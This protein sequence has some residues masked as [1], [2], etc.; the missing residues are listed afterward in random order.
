MRI[1][2][3]RED[4]VR[5][6][7]LRRTKSTPSPPPP[8]PEGSE[9]DNVAA[10]EK[11]LE[12]CKNPTS[13]PPSPLDAG[14]RA[15][16][17]PSHDAP[18]FEQQSQKVY[19][20]PS[21]SVPSPSS[22][23]SL[24]SI[25]PQ[26][27]LKSENWN[28]PKSTAGPNGPLRSYISAATP[29]SNHHAPYTPCSSTSSASVS[30][31]YEGS[32][33]KKEMG[34]NGAYLAPTN[35]EPATEI[36]LMG[37]GGSTSMNANGDQ[38]S[39]PLADKL[40][41]PYPRNTSAPSTSQP[42][43]LWPP[44]TSSTSR[45]TDYYR[46]PPSKA[47]GRFDTVDGGGYYTTAGENALVT[48][49]EN[50]EE[51]LE[52]I[53]ELEGELSS[54]EEAALEAEG[55][56][57]GG[58]SRKPAS[59]PF[60]GINFG[61]LFSASNAHS[62]QLIM[63]A[64]LFYPKL[65]EYLLRASVQGELCVNPNDGV[66]MSP[67]NEGGPSSLGL[68]AALPDSPLENVLCKL[69]SM[70][71]D[72]LFHMVDWVNRT[73]V[74][75]VIP[76]EDK[77]QLLYSSWSE[78]IVIEFLQCLILNLRMDDRPLG[79]MK[80]DSGSPGEPSNRDLYYLVKEL[81]EYLLASSDDNQRL[82]DLIARFDMLRLSGHEFTCL[83]FL[84]IFN[85]YKH[86]VKLTS[87]SE[88]VR[89]VQA[90]LCHFLLRAAR[91]SVKRSPPPPPPFVD[92]ST[93][94]STLATIAASERLGQLLSRL[95]EV[96]HVAFQLENFLVA[97]YYAS[98]IPNASLLTEMLLTKRRGGRNPIG[99]TST[100]QPTPPAVS[101]YGFT[102][103]SQPHLKQDPNDYTPIPPPTLP[104]WRPS[105]SGEGLPPT[106]FTAST[107]VPP[108]APTQYFPVSSAS[109]SSDYQQSS[110]QPQDQSFFMSPPPP[111]P[112]QQQPHT[113]SASV[114]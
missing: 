15:T 23:C 103:F 24:N 65:K 16:S 39:L 67:D 97:R 73:E 2:A 74:F 42:G 91:R 92:F 60:A 47:S 7:R 8:S 12:I 104:S 109:S 25:N 90:E 99:V 22:A 29:T 56:G 85:P 64:K 87:S 63:L 26:P 89:E 50:V 33:L 98:Y 80:A 19:W 69:F 18:S 49:P 5:G 62:E 46:P 28:A 112:P 77:M 59:V 83:K 88:Y 32:A 66:F 55:L 17:C 57:F 9:G 48:E 105:G 54:E 61:Q 106:P 107:T 10:T 70:L 45:P 71:E 100:L 43:A 81:I 44:R 27:E 96:K 102:P 76:V 31:L 38:T 14:L 40:Q 78:V 51:S 41:Y 82:H 11:K 36:P 58:S 108:L 114:I 84:V 110:Q 13:E 21:A 34:D 86:D 52:E 101:D 111:P 79:V 75:R 93:H 113:P 72:C 95:T 37:A 4:R 68:S 6:G 35:S 1:G 53:S 3:V 20:N 30:G 94:A